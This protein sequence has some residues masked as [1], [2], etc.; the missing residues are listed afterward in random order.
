MSG[1]SG[2]YRGPYQPAN[3]HKYK[4]NIE[5]IRYRSSWEL[6]VM[7]WCDYSP[8]VKRWSSEEVVIPYRSPHDNQIHR[9]FM[10]FWVEMENGMIYLWEVK[11]LEQTVRPAA[12]KRNTPASQAKYI[13]AALTYKTNMAKWITA[14]KFAKERNWTFKVMTERA[15]SKYGIIIKD[16]RTK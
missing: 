5:K 10:D 4:G 3:R 15:L 2:T 13:E 12:P 9:Y 11:P 8:L 16:G 7:K 1:K 14:D 6:A